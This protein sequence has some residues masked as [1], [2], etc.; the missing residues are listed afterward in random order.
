MREMPITTRTA[1]TE[2]GHTLTLKYVMLVGETPDGPE[3]YGVKIT[4]ADSAASAAA[5]GL[6]MNAQRINDLI[7]TLANNTITPTGLMDVLAD[8]L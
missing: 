1:Q 6:T 8:W 3:N 2:D 7:E 5:P 4:E